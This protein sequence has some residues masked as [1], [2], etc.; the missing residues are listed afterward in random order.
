MHNPEHTLLLLGGQALGRGGCRPCY[1]FA[2]AVAAAVAAATASRSAVAQAASSDPWPGVTADADR[3]NTYPCI[4]TDAISHGA[5]QGA[6]AYVIASYIK[7][8]AMSGCDIAL[9]DKNGQGDIISNLRSSR[10]MGIPATWELGAISTIGP[11]RPANSG[12]CPHC[13]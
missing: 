10:N 12:V 7:F 9:S 2:D 8:K 5:D 13:A 3:S 1:C 11:S 4:I 6:T